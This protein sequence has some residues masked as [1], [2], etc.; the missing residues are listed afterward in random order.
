MNRIE[1]VPSKADVVSPEIISNSQDSLYARRL[2]QL[3]QFDAGTLTP[4]FPREALVELSNWCNHA[5]VFCANARMERKKGFLNLRLYERFVRE[6]VALGLKEIGL[7]TTGEP[8]FTKNLDQYVATA[9]KAGVRYVF[10]TT[11]GA[12]ATPDRAVPVIEAGL[13]SIKFSVNAGSR[14]TYSLVHGHDDFDKVIDNITFISRYRDVRAPHLRLMASCA[15]TRMVEG[16]KDRIKDI[17]LSLVDDV[18]F[19][20]VDGQ[21]GQSLEQLPLLK[22]A[23]SPAIPQVGEAQPCAMLWNRVH[24]TWE[25]YLTLCCID[26]E[27]ALTYAD[28]KAA[29]SLAEAWNNTIIVRM[30][31]RHQTQE[32]RGTLCQNCLYGTQETV[33]HLTTIGHEDASASVISG[34]ANG[35]AWV[36]ARINTLISIHKT[37]PDPVCPEDNQSEPR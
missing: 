2:A 28:F 25:G 35:V 31:R 36:S 8:F 20:G 14:E 19:F 34:N 11:N 18:V 17:L 32:L 12:L 13:S 5:C 24:L 23:M 3:E 7:Y 33:K 26:Y 10:L 29:G 9:K 37:I 27:N 21:S 30:R 15:V 22:S 1:S 16:E 6:A 4:P